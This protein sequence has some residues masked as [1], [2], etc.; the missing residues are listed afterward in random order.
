[1]T[2]MTIEIGSQV[3]GTVEVA[4]L[5]NDEKTV[6]ELPVG[7]ELTVSDAVAAAAAKEYSCTMGYFI[8]DGTAMSALPTAGIAEGSYCFIMST[9]DMKFLSAGQWR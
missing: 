4:V 7:I 5:E 8:T 6:Y 1:M 3:C 9:G 2:K